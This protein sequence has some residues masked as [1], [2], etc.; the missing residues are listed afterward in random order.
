[1]EKIE[2]PGGKTGFL[3]DPSG[4]KCGRF[5]HPACE[6][7]K[8]TGPDEVMGVEVPPGE[9]EGG[10]DQTVFIRPAVGAG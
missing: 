2:G 10:V 8:E 3:L 9:P 5:Q 1:M 4:Q 6:I 7:E